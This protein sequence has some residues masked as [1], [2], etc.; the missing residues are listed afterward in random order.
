[1]ECGSAAY[2]YDV[3]LD[4]EPIHGER[5]GCVFKLVLSQDLA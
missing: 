3:T 5:S 4:D 1:M 2:N